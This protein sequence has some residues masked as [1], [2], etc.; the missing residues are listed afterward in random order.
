MELEKYETDLR[1]NIFKLVLKQKLDRLTW[2]AFT[3]EQIE[4]LDKDYD[5]IYQLYLEKIEEKKK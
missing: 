3:Q 1:E 4:K 2:V 5:S